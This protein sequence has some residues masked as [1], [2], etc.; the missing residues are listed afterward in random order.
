MKKAKKMRQRNYVAKNMPTNGTGIH[1]D[2]NGKNMS[3]ARRKHLENHNEP[4]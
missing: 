4:M 3:R 1:K 2:K